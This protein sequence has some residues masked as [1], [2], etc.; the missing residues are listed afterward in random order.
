MN[1]KAG[2]YSDQPLCHDI[3]LVLFWYQYTELQIIDRLAR[4]QRLNIY[5][6]NPVW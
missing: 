4:L 2:H 1:I 5:S 3:I 6:Y